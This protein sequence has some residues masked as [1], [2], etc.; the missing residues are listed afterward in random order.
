MTNNDIIPIWQ[1]VGYSTNHLAKSVGNLYGVKATH[2][3]TLDPMAEGVILV[4]LGDSR[5]KRQEV[6]SLIKEYEFE[7]IFGLSTDSFDSM[8]FVQKDETHRD[9]TINTDFIEN[10]CDSFIGKYEQKV[11]IFSA[12]L[13]KGKKLF[14]WGHLKEEVPLP[15]KAGEI[16]DLKLFG[17]EQV[18]LKIIVQ[19]IL[20][21]IRDIRGNF[22]QQ[23][24]IENWAKYLSTIEPNSKVYKA[25]FKVQMTRGLYVRSLSQDIAERLGTLGFVYSLV[26]TKNGQYTK[27]DCKNL[28]DIF[29]Q[30]YDKILK[31]PN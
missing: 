19:N 13:Y 24:I 3:G 5:L 30:E 14:E 1:P 22:R 16:L 27:K 15:S 7:I 20:K 18:S 29:G 21:K 31:L 8:G 2:T 9:L 17:F 11:P 4:L 6:S 12:Q 26:R 10:V 23:E 25:S 28:S